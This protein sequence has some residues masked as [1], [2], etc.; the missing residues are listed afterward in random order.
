LLAKAKHYKKRPILP[1]QVKCCGH[2]PAHCMGMHRGSPSLVQFIAAHIH[3]S[4]WHQSHEFTRPSPYHCFMAT[5][6]LWSLSNP[7]WHPS[8]W[9]SP[10]S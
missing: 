10:P 3:V 1:G 6:L 7:K 5:C 4:P 2:G 9:P 8:I